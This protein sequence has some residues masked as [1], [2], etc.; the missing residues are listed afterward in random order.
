M[1]AG[2]PYGR[3]G[4]SFEEAIRLLYLSGVLD[5][6]TKAED[7]AHSKAVAEAI[8]V[9]IRRAVEDRAPKIVGTDGRV[10]ERER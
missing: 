7:S 2:G 4:L 10:L 8:K 1:V 5:G 6:F 9:E 3:L